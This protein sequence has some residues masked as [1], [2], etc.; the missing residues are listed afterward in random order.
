[1][2]LRGRLLRIGERSTSPTLRLG[3]SD[4]STD[5]G[6][7]RSYANRMTGIRLCRVCSRADRSDCGARTP[8]PILFWA[9]YEHIRMR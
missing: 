8:I 3:T 9:K 7:Y 6:Q 2:T 5:T 4:A 1:M